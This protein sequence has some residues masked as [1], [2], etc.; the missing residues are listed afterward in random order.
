MVLNYPE[1]LDTFMF[2]LLTCGSVFAQDS[3]GELS[4]RYCGQEHYTRSC[5]KRWGSKDLALG[6]KFVNEIP[7]LS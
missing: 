5:N 4:R 6:E 1:V 3:L 2:L 7:Y